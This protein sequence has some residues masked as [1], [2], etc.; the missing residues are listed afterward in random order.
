MDRV[1]PLNM[2]PKKIQKNVYAIYYASDGELEKMT[3]YVDMYTGEFLGVYQE[4]V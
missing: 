1:R 3:G 4:G 2:I